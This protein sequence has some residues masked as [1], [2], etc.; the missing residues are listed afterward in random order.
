M[1]NKNVTTKFF[2]FNADK[3]SSATVRLFNFSNADGN[4]VKTDVLSIDSKNTLILLTLK[5]VM[6]VSN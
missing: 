1:N 6:N 5:K 2:D 4:W 3:F